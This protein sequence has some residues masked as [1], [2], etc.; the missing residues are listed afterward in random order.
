MTTPDSPQLFYNDSYAT[1]DD[2]ETV[3]D[4]LLRHGHDIP[5]GCR[6]GACQACVMVAEDHAP[7][8]HATQ[9]LNE[10]QITLGH[11]LSCQCK[12]SESMK[13]TLPGESSNKVSAQVLEKSM[14]N[15]DVIQLTLQADLDFLA[16]QYITLFK[17]A[18]T[19]RSYS[20]ASTPEEGVITLHIKHIHHGAFS[21]WAKTDLNTGDKITLQGPMG[22]CIYTCDTQAPLFLAGVGTGL[23]PL[24]GIL[25]QALQVKHQGQIHLVLG[26]K[27]AQ[28]FYLVD[29]LHQLTEK[30]PNLACHLISQD[31]P[32]RPTYGGMLK[33]GDLYQYCRELMPSMTGQQVFL[34]G[35][36]SFVKKMKRQCFMAGASMRDIRADAFLPCA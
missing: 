19:A 28:Q 3:L 4:A 5:H 25:K 20:I 2:G 15:D 6:A 35:A 7:P 26:S 17:N 31:S 14:L 10:A 30:Q 8:A 22:Q 21:H 27:Q 24:Y 33:Q 23:A 29:T 34:C 32:N 12:P 13:L 18:C 36:D 11:F 9:G 1:F 16:G